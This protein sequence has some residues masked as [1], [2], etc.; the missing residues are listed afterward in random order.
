MVDWDCVGGGYNDRDFDV[1][2]GPRPY[3]VEQSKQSAK[4]GANKMEKQERKP[5]YEFYVAGVQH[6]E[7]HTCIDELKVGT[8]LILRAEPSNRF[9]PNAVRIE[10][11][12]LN[13]HKE[14]MLGYVPAKKG[15]YSSKVSAAM[16]IRRLGC[17][18]TELDPEAKTWSQL[19]V[20][21]FDMEGK[22]EETEDEMYSA[23][24]SDPREES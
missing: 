3:E 14:I 4:Q 21:I 13:Q 17:E 16:E 2:E 18:V 1:D 19:A 5:L 10:F 8:P 22:P 24:G 7:L 12:S 11:H 15:D 9:D 6:H 20:G 23:V